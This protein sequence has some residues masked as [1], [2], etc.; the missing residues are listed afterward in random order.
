MPAASDPGLFHTIYTTRALRRFKPDPVPD[1]LLFQVIDAGIRAATGGARQ[2]ARFVIVRDVA[3]RR[4][5][6]AWYWERWLEYGRQYIDD[7]S[8]IERLPRQ[9]RLVTRSAAHLAAHIGEVPVHLFVVGPKRETPL[10]V[11]G[12]I[13]P[14][15]QNMLLTIRA[16]GL[17][18]VLTTFHRHREQ[19]VCALLGI[20]ET[21]ETYALLPIGYPTD[22]QGPVRRSLPVAQVAFADGWEQPWTYAAA[23]PPDGL[24]DR[25]GGG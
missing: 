15:I 22:R 20:P 11:G 17:G 19:E 2:D 1:D 5:I 23:Q 13:Y 12:S 7:P 9:Q 14:C 8:A 24:L 25:W 18:S 6:A 10:A 16:L 4:Q 21:H 3:K